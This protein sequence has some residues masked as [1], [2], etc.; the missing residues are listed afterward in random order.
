MRRLG[1]A[2]VGGT[3]GA[4]VGTQLSRCGRHSPVADRS[5]TST[6][7][8]GHDHSLTVTEASWTAP[9]LAGETFV[10]TNNLDHTHTVTLT[11]VQLAAIGQGEIVTAK[12]S[13]NG[14]DHTFRIVL[15]ET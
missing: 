9:P 3:V 8:V 14:H 10:T 1:G 15:K 13:S 11:Y 2:V 4:L 7:T 12:S 5:F 6:L